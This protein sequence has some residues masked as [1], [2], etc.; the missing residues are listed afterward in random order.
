MDSNSSMDEFDKSWAIKPKQIEE[1][2]YAINDLIKQMRSSNSSK[3]PL[4]KE[5]SSSEQKSVLQRSRTVSSEYMHF[6]FTCLKLTI[7]VLSTGLFIILIYL[8]NCEILDVGQQFQVDYINKVC[9]VENRYRM[10]SINFDR[11]MLKMTYDNQQEFDRRENIENEWNK[12]KERNR[13]K[14]LKKELILQKVDSLRNR[15]EFANISV[16]LLRITRNDSKNAK[17]WRK[18]AVD[19]DTVFVKLLKFFKLK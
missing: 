15:E 7:R 18:K 10:N 12:K 13:I 17:T 3:S 5:T 16:P 8:A 2:E 14:K 1:P 11:K 19:E 6:T 9:F 4:R